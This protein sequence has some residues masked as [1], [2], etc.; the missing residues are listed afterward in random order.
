MVQ[1]GWL[2]VTFLTLAL[3]HADAI[4]GPYRPAPAYRSRQ[5]YGGWR[6]VRTARRPSLHQSQYA[7]T[8]T[9]RLEP[10]RRTAWE[11]RT[12]EKASP[13]LG[14]WPESHG[15][16]WREHN[17]LPY[18]LRVNSTRRPERAIVD[19]ILRETGQETWH[20]DRVASLTANSNQLRVYHDPQVQARVAE[21]VD[22][23]VQGEPKQLSFRV[24]VVGVDDPQWRR[25]AYAILQP[26]PGST[27]G[28]QSWL[29][30]PEDASLLMSDLRN[31]RNFKE[32][33]A[34]HVFIFNGQTATIRS[35]R[36]RSYV[37]NVRRQPTTYPG[38]QL[39]LD[40][41]DEGLVVELSPLATVDG[42]YL[43]A[44]VKVHVDQIEEMREV[45][46]DA[47]TPFA[48]NQQTR[49]QVPQVAQLRVEERFHWPTNKVL[50]IGLGVAPAAAP[51]QSGGLLNLG[52]P[53][54]QDLLV[55]VEVTKG[56]TGNPRLTRFTNRPRYRYRYR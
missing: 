31:R 21:I 3:T 24:R 49:V 40:R 5:Q 36:E 51:Q 22:R 47:G 48:P 4:A 6:P 23:F 32:H 19:W 26:V 27:H 10:I 18:T 50:L 11:S 45:P 56:P 43:D 28:P 15:Q 52:G 34:S 38:Y 12:A 46:I 54:R 16:V 8:K 33:A 55:F 2:V 13:F 35:T 37:R 14:P 42:Q 44:Y 9:A 25:R 39:E 53:G 29:L 17:I 41:V 20:G 1:N 7:P 30:E